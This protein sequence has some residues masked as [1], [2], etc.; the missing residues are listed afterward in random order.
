VVQEAGDEDKVVKLYKTSRGKKPAAEVHAQGKARVGREILDHLKAQNDPKERTRV[1]EERGY[2]L[3]V[4]ERLQDK[5]DQ[6]NAWIAEIQDLQ[7]QVVDLR[8]QLDAALRERDQL[9]AELR[10]VEAVER[11]KAIAQTGP[12]SAARLAAMDDAVR[13]ER[14]EMRSV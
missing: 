7:K 13:V 3:I 6:L 12:D 8:M 1:E 5:T 4:A 10:L 9:Q 14:A 2:R 11:L